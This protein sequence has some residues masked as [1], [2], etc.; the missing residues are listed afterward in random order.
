M[1][2]LNVATILLLAAFSGCSFSLPQS[3]NNT[4]VFVLSAEPSRVDRDKLPASELRILIRDTTSSAFLSGKKIV[5]SQTPGT[6]GHYQFSF[7][8]EPPPRAFL[9]IVLKRFEESVAF[10]SIL[11]VSTA[12]VADIQLSLSLEELYHDVSHSPGAANVTVSGELVDLRTREL[13]ARRSFTR[14]LEPESYDAFGA[15][16]AFN[17]A[18]NQIADELLEWSAQ[19]LTTVTA[20]AGDK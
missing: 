2:C 13:I 1:R 12:A 9:E 8:A 16:S 4:E 7:W 10:R 5:F 15:A 11:R 19:M 20:P 6:R 14:K 17:Q 3:D 18:L